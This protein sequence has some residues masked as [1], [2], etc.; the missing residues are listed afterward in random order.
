MLQ[1]TN[2]RKAYEAQ[3][4]LSIPE[5]KLEP[6]IYW[7][8]GENGAGKSTFLKSIAGIIPFE[9]EVRVHD[10]SLRRQRMQFTKNVSFGDAEPVFPSFLT[11]NDLVNFFQDTK[12]R[13]NRTSDELKQRF[14]VQRYLGNKVGTYSSGM[15]KK[16]SLVLAFIGAPK[17]IL[18][19]EPFITLDTDAV[20]VLQE[21]IA[22]CRD[23]S[24]IISSHQEL[25]LASPFQVLEIQQQTII[26][27][28]HVLA[29]Q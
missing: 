27:A 14:G 21:V 18:L 17:L 9:G 1:L 23:I 12:G 22:G 7:L 4:V 26:Q 16:L 5:L 20:S 28:K 2:F 25:S 19:D 10:V 13:M 3:T 6:A 11:G 8:K 15:L 24:F 29:V